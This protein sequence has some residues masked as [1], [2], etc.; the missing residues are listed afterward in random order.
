MFSGIGVRILPI[1]PP[2][3]LGCAILPRSGSFSI[4]GIVSYDPDLDFNNL[5]CASNSIVDRL[6][7][8]GLGWID[9]M[10]IYFYL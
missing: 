8:I 10:A 7:V 9:D 3:L 4:C 5:I 6:Q 2:I 1:L